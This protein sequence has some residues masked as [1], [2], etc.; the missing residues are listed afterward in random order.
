MTQNPADSSNLIIVS[1]QAVT[2]RQPKKSRFRNQR[3]LGG[4]NKNFA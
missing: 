2:K 1:K 3:N 4:C